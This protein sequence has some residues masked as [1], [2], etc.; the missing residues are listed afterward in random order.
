[1]ILYNV[2]VNM[3]AGIHTDWLTWMQSHYLPELMKTGIFTAC[4]LCRLIDSPNEGI[5]YSI[6][7]FCDSMQGY[8]RYQ[9]EYSEQFRDMHLEKFGNKYVSFDTLMEIVEEYTVSNFSLN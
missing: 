4:K 3:E 7:Y 8:Q 5:T 9:E 1:M 2:T 6:Q